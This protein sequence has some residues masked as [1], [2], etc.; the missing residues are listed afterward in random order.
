MTFQRADFIHDM[1]SQIPGSASEIQNLIA[2]MEMS[3]GCLGNQIQDQR[4]IGKCL[5]SCFQTTESFH[6]VV[7]AAAYFLNR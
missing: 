4:R 6:V 2:F 1:Q 7:E 5:L 3:R